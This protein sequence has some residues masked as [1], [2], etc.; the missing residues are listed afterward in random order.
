MK[1]MQDVQPRRYQIWKNHGPGFKKTTMTAT[2]RLRKDR[3]QGLI[4]HTMT[5]LILEDLV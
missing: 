3:G 2:R 1:Q 4:E 5:H